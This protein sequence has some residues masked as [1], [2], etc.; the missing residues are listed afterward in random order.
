MNNERGQ[1]QWLLGAFA[2]PHSMNTEREVSHFN[3]N[4]TIHQENYEI[5]QISQR[6]NIS[7][8]CVGT[9]YFDTRPAVIAFLEKKERRFR[10]ADTEIYKTHDFT[11]KFFEKETTV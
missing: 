10:P 8:N 2:A 6:L 1:L 7:L 11:R 4:K 3:K 9:A 5:H